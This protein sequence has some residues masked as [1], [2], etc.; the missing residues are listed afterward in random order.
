M[1]VF[2]VQID[3]VKQVHLSKNQTLNS[4]RELSS[5]VQNMLKKMVTV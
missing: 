5:T 1:K 2:Q 4:L 3:Q